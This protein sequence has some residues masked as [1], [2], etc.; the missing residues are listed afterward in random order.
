M[1]NPFK[2][3]EQ[4]GV[5]I[6]EGR[7]PESAVPDFGPDGVETVI[8]VR[9]GDGSVHEV[10]KLSGV[11]WNPAP[12]SVIELGEPNR[13]ARVLSQV[14]MVVI[15]KVA[16]VVCVADPATAHSAG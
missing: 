12:G 5:A 16:S 1:S 10:L 15:G 3:V 8:C 11:L 6:Q 14:Y 4:D 2:I 9:E 7:L 13:D